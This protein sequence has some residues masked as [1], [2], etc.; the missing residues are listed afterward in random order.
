MLPIHKKIYAEMQKMGIRDTL[1]LSK[2]I[3]KTQDLVKTMAEIYAR[4]PKDQQ[5]AV[6]LAVA[7]ILL[8]PYDNPAE[9]KAV[10]KKIQAHLI[11]FAKMRGEAD[12]NNR[13]T[14]RNKI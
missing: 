1:L 14:N 4:F 8:Q 7:L 11:N 3:L 10:L 9:I 5:K 12:G 2:A 13:N 6:A